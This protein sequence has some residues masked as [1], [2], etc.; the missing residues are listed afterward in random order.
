MNRTCVTV[1]VLVTLACIGGESRAGL[2][3]GLFGAG[4]G[5][6]VGG[7]C[8]AAPEGFSGAGSFSAEV[9]R[10]G[11]F[12]R[13]RRARV[14]SNSGAPQAMSFSAPTTAGASGGCYS[15]SYSPQSQTYSAPITQTYSA[16]TT[17]GAGEGCYSSSYAP[18][19]QAYMVA[20]PQQYQVTPAP[21]SRA[22]PSLPSKTVPLN[23]EYTPSRLAQNG[24]MV[25]PGVHRSIR[26][27]QPHIESPERR[28]T[29]K[30]ACGGQCCGGEG[31]CECG[32]N[33]GCG[34]PPS[35]PKRMG[36]T[37]LVDYSGMVGRD[38]LRLVDYNSV[39]ETNKK[40][41]TSMR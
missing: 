41:R 10:I 7:M 27:I 26:R 2:F 19:S 8:V 22:M 17:F 24:A 9:E 21:Q 4:G 3:S 5:A 36:G 12:G 18:Q 35:A 32:E 28:P 31:D 20:P 25:T 1:I 16:P 6:C 13:V 34:S 39:S 11:L 38:V 33:C 29:A 40:V 37:R 14:S 23:Q 15:S 30:I